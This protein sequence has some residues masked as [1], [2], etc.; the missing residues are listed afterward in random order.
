MR[1]TAVESCPELSAAHLPLLSSE[2]LL[3]C[4]GCTFSSEPLPGGMVQT[5]CPL[6]RLPC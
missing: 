2:P 1:G 3:C 6:K 4:H 5:I